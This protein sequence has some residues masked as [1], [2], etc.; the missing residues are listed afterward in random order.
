MQTELARQAANAKE[1]RARLLNPPIN[2]KRE[3]FEQA[4]DDIAGLRAKIA[5]LASELAAR[6]QRIWK[7]ELDVADRNARLLAQADLIGTLD[8]AGV[9]V[10]SGKKPVAAIVAEVLKDFPDVTWDDIIGVRRSRA[11]V[12]PRHR[13][14]IA[15][16]E[17]RSDLSL[18]AIG[19]IFRRDHTSILATVDKY[20]TR[21]NAA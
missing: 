1:V 17:Q 18:P 16:Y 7:L 19:R 12:V 5:E 6:N 3:H 4:R 10:R 2:L 21:R 13:C 20:G 15:V 9:F 11:L 14:M 8:N